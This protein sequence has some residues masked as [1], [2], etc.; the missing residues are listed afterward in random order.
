MRD[1]LLRNEMLCQL[2]R[3]NEHLAVSDSNIDE[4]QKCICTLELTGHDAS[5]AKTLLGTFKQLRQSHQ[6]H[7][8]TIVCSLRESGQ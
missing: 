4:Q 3:C 1:K 8:D 7:H 2:A 6:D 5:F